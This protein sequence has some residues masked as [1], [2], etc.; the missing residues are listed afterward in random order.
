MAERP[1]VERL[2]EVR[3]EVRALLTED[4][5]TL[6]LLQSELV[7]ARRQLELSEQDLRDAVD[8]FVAPSFEDIAA[9][10]S[11]AAR[12]DAEEEQL[13]S[14]LAQWDVHALIS[15]DVNR[16]EDEVQMVAAQLSAATAEIESRR[17]H[18]K[19]F[20]EVFDEIVRELE[21]A[22]YQP[23]R[24]DLKTFLPW[25]GNAEFKKLSGGQR[26]VV[27]VAY[28]LA[29][30]TVGLVNPNV[31]VPSLLILDTPS[32][33][34]GTKDREQISRDYRRIA[35]I[36]D[37]YATPIQIL[38]ADNDPPPSGVKPTR[39]IELTYDDPLVPG[40]EHPGESVEGIFPRED[41]DSDAK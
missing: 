25:I 36:V 40:I 29:L 32:K 12:A 34:L 38:V 19:E 39:T 3:E 23:A 18:V 1:E 35:A 37:A 27:T 20:S 5:Q 33:Y 13:R 15:A 26:T 4:H 6:L 11:E 8:Q 41:E 24:I 28:H 21:L 17:E 22:W 16:A 9:L 30:L 10:S 7:R 14:V 31:Q 2:H